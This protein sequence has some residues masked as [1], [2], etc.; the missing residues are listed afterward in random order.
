MYVVEGD[1]SSTGVHWFSVF[2]FLNFFELGDKSWILKVNFIHQFFFGV[3]YYFF[4]KNFAIG[5][6][7]FTV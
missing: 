4:I 2:H 3:V 7:E 1:D 6:V 5:T